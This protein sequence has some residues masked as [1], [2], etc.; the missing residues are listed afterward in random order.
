MR[1]FSF[2]IFLAAFILPFLA[3]AQVTQISVPLGGNCF[4]TSA[5]ATTDS[6]ADDGIVRWQSS[7]TI[8]SI[9]FRNDRQ[10]SIQFGLEVES[11]IKSHI[12]VSLDKDQTTLSFTNSNSAAFTEKTFHL[13]PGYHCIQL[14]GIQKNGEAFGVVTSLLLRTNAPD[15]IFHFVRENSGN[16][17]YWGRR[18]PSLH[19]NYQTPAGKNIEW[20]YTELTVNKGDDAVGSYFMANGFKE[21]YFGM[22]VNSDSERHILF[23]IWSPFNTDNPS[24]IPEDQKIVLLKKGADVHAG[25]FGDE[26][27]GGQSYFNYLWTAG[28]T[29]RFLTH[30]QPDT[31][32]NT[33]YT[34]YFFAPEKN[35]WE[36]IASFQRPKTNTWL[37]KPHSFI[38]N[39]I[40]TN[41]FLARRCSYGNQWALDTE[42]K[43]HE[44]TNAIFTGDDIANS[45]YRM[46]FKGGAAGNA[47][48]LQNG[49]F[50]N[51]YV[52]LKQ[53]FKRKAN[54]VAP[55]ID[56]SKLP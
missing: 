6:V 38:E 37:T 32:G 39:F 9:Y 3:K 5:N 2:T 36:L 25:E 43:W 21:G 56:F 14:K 31:K 1:Y 18:G 11:T 54:N 4:I 7:E 24:A 47:F 20:L 50:F 52:P 8:F 42:G 53:Y 13:T 44:L 10:C 33:I 23:S 34:S 22:Q 15:S 26:G 17:Y 35:E 28:N 16:R 55:Q 40:D 46:D 12:S 41:G 30:V 49:G 45:H 19:L 51:D 27:S 29:Y 48:F